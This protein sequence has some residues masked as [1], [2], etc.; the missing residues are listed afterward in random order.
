MPIA[1]HDITGDMLDKAKQGK[2][3]LPSDQHHQP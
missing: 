1:S 3:R 2:I